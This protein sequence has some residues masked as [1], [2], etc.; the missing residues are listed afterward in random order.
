MKIHPDG[1][2]N[3]GIKLSQIFI[4][5]NNIKIHLDKELTHSTAACDKPPNT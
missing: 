3:I 1:S 4:K 5:S 2:F